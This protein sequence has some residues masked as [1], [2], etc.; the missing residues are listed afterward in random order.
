MNFKGDP[1]SK[2]LNK[3]MSY[4]LEDDVI[5]LLCRFSSRKRVSSGS[6]A[7]YDY[8]SYLCIK[9]SVV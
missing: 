9:D 7:I 4:L 6:K 1:A 5:A 2:Y 8:V 3:S